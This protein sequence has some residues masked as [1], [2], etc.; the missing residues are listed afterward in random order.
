MIVRMGE[1]IMEIALDR[2]LWQEKMGESGEN[3]TRTPIHPLRI[4]RGV[5]EARTR[6]H[7]VGSECSKHLVMERVLIILNRFNICVNNVSTMTK[8]QLQHAT[9]AYL[10]KC[11]DVR[12]RLEHGRL[13]G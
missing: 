5:T 1:V 6:D 4:P 10:C 7:N 3:P 13:A 11:L 8:I 9:Y 12:T 2:N